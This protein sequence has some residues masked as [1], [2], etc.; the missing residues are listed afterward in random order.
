MKDV[1]LYSRYGDRYTLKYID[2]N[3]YMFERI[4]YLRIGY[5]KDDT[6]IFIDPPGGP[7]INMGY[8]IGSKF[9]SKISLQDKDFIIEVK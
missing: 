2:D 9:V 4:P 3:H 6:I 7:F 5:D 1:K 8:R